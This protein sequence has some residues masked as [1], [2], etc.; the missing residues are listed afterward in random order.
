MLKSQLTSILQARQV[1]G[2]VRREEVQGPKSALRLW[3]GQVITYAQSYGMLLHFHVLTAS[4]RQTRQ[5]Y[6]EV[7]KEV[8]Q[9]AFQKHL[10]TLKSKSS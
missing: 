8:V 10:W 2:E 7:T 3:H 9:G 5:V 6:G 4:K 1:C